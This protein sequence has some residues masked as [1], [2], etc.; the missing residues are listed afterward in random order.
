MTGRSHSTH[1]L[2]RFSVSWVLKFP[3][4]YTPK[5]SADLTDSQVEDLK[6]KVDPVV[7]LQAITTN[8]FGNDFR[9]S[10]L[11]HHLCSVIVDDVDTS[12]SKFI[13]AG[14]IP[15]ITRYMVVNIDDRDIQLSSCR[16]LAVMAE[17]SDEAQNNIAEC[18][19]VEAVVDAATSY[20]TD[21]DIQRVCIVALHNFSLHQANR[22]AMHVSNTLLAVLKAFCVVLSLPTYVVL[23][24]TTL[25]TAVFQ[26]DRSRLIVGENGAIDALIEALRTHRLKADVQR[27]CNLALQNIM[28]SCPHNISR[29]KEL[30]GMN[31]IF[32]GILAHLT[33]PLVV[34]SA[35]CALYNFI[36]FDSSAGHTMIAEQR[37]LILTCSVAKNMG[38]DLEIADQVIRIWISICQYDTSVEKEG[39]RHL[40]EC[41]KNT[42]TG[43]IILKWMR[44]S[45][46]TQNQR[47]FGAVC[48]L[49]EVMSLS[50]G[51]RRVEPSLTLINTG[52]AIGLCILA[53]EAFERERYAILDALSTLG[54]LIS[55]RDDFKNRFNE[56]DGVEAVVRVMRSNL[57]DETINIES[58]RILDIA[59]EGQLLSARKLRGKEALCRAVLNCMTN[60][61]DSA[62]IQENAIS[63]LVK[64]SACC[65]VDAM[66]LMIA[67]VCAVLEM[68]L[69][70]HKEN[71]GV[72]SLAS[73]LMTVLEA[74]NEGQV[75]NEK[76]VSVRD[77][78]AQ[79]RS[80]SRIIQNSEAVRARALKSRS[81]IVLNKNGR[82]ASGDLE[83]RK[84][85]LKSFN[86][87]K[88]SKLTRSNGETI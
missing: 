28:F 49:Y 21:I 19:V 16:M 61:E 75:S 55:G 80:R 2:S 40:T 74:V 78:L 15:L 48:R 20:G 6:T 65:K 59:A 71:P 26:D 85:A 56:M 69:M 24:A 72:E 87:L 13:A 11:Y 53:F 67:D 63:V 38:Q 50:L 45:I 42:G 51:K 34:K 70:K 57:M 8:G 66:E 73:Q 46:L 14:G 86:V 39:I 12:R 41:M 88:Q 79:K 54:L 17:L 52:K 10:V 4:C 76:Y 37:W 3:T 81:P 64:V 18:E 25:A 36:G 33:N 30:N 84:R 32:Y 43:S 47:L 83:M 58:C 9:K 7:L 77:C 60:F 29:F 68:A 1:R 27:A 62:A 44:K 82:L 35:F 23:A 5:P 31:V 22:S